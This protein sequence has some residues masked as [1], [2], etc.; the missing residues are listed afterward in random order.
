[1]RAL[2]AAIPISL[3]PVHT[4]VPGRARLRV[5][6]LRGSPQLA[7][8]LWMGLS[9][10]P[11]INWVRA[12]ELTGNLTVEF[13]RSL[14]LGALNAVIRA[15]LR[16][17]VAHAATG[18]HHWHASP[19]QEVVR[20]L[21]THANSG[22]TQESAEHHLHTHGRNVVKIAAPRSALNI[23]AAQFTS[24]PVAVLAGAAVLSICTGV[25]FEAVAIGTVLAVNGLIGLL[26]EAHAE[27]TLRSLKSSGPAHAR[28]IR[29][30]ATRR[31]PAA[32]VVP[33][34]M[35]VLRRGTLIAADARVI[36]DQNLSVTEAMLTGESVP[37]TKTADAL[38]AVSTPLAEHRNMVYRGTIVTSGSGTAVV[39]A[40]GGQTEAGRVQRLV[41]ASEPPETPTY[42]QLTRLGMRLAWVT[43][44]ASLVLFAIGRLHGFGMLHML[45]SAVSLAV[46]SVPEGLPMVATTTHAI[47]VNALRENEVFVRRLDAIETLASVNVVCFDKTGTLTENRMTV[48]ELCSGGQRYVAGDER[49]RGTIEPAVRAL[50]ETGCLCSEAELSSR[51]GA[52][53]LEG[54][55]TEV[56]LVRCAQRNGVAVEVVRR[57]K[58][59]LS[60]QQRTETNRFMITTHNDQGHVLIAM[61]GN[62]SDVL[63]RCQY[64]A[65]PV[66]RLRPLTP[67]RRAAIEGHNATMASKGLRVL[68]FA[69]A[70]A[71]PDDVPAS[72]DGK[73][74]WL[75][76]AGLHDPIRPSVHQLVRRLHR[77]GVR[78]I[79]LTG[80]QCS[81]AKA[82]AKDIGLAG[83]AALSVLEG[84]EISHLTDSALAREASNAH[85]FARIT[86][87]Q[88]LMI[89]RAL[90]DSGAI[91]AMVGDGINDSPALRAAHVGAAM[92]MNGD[93]AAREVADLFLH[94]EDLG[95]LALAVEQGRT[96]HANIRKSLRFILS[97]N[98]SEVMLML[99]AT[100]LGLG[101]GLTPIQLLWINIVTDVLPGIGLAVEE[102]DPLALE[103]GPASPELPL[104]G[105]SE[106]GVLLSEGATLAAGALLAG[107]YGAI[108]FG[109]NSHQMRS[110]TF[111]SLVSAQLQH[112]LA[113][114]APGENIFQR[115]DLK[116]NPILTK[117]LIGSFVLQAGAYFVAPL[118]RA[119]GLAPI[120]FG[121]GVITA[122]SSVLP[123]LVTLWRCTGPQ[124]QLDEKRIGA[125]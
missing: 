21:D 99:A 62:P 81:T 115:T 61:K 113:C 105:D 84:T 46:A 107:T 44:A 88:K 123:S 82:V 24:L 8:H 5:G 121:A 51:E 90:Q 60:L 39:V 74:V 49:I 7:R 32:H 94:T 19:P 55:S 47:G 38:H 106:I 34:D 73:M 102:A 45:R 40:T 114:R 111:G 63:A 13:D 86:P 1:M 30:G 14:G 78:T 75:G 66:D 122:F 116:S 69:H 2:E 4:R 110:M 67:E 35:L 112:A 23:F 125:L 65:T 58:P 120:G 25:I 52:P 104:L 6:G 96:T 43:G 91:I 64:E 11:R 80:D 97:T 95:R 85:V 22:L 3:V 68:G 103:K 36:S 10:D 27:T 59:R 16:G 37:V 119:L 79:M 29:G 28:V 42:Q 33:G 15:V 12:S 83:G 70:Y 57:E 124:A 20:R 117:I 26:T 31:V 108:R 72:V 92:G 48:A 54:S 118:R 56:A 76:A 100:A 98:S 41:D 101:E 17:E 71:E 18:G 93:A 77:A 53:A 50:L 89:V 9:S 87:G 109:A